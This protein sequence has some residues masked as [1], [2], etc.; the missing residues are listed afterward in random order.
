MQ[1][2]FDI[3]RQYHGEAAASEAQEHFITVFQK[4]EIPD[5]ALP[6]PISDKLMTNGLFDL[7]RIISASG[8]APSNSEARRLILQGGVKVN[9]IK[10]TDLQV[11]DLKDGDVIQVGKK[12]FIKLTNQ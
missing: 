9:G 12:S 8:F 7:V 10:T 4:K 2:A 6:M 5:T 11:P 3:T 1:L